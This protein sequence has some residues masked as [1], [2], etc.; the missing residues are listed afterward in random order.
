MSRAVVALG[1]NLG[2]RIGTLRAAVEEIGGLGTVLAVSGVFETDPVGGPE[3][4]A[5]LNA[6]LLLETGLT[7]QALLAALQAI[8]TGHGRTREVRWGARTLDLDIL[9]F[10]GLV[11]DEPDLVLPHPR[12][13]ERAFVLVPWLDADPDA[14]VVGHGPASALLAAIGRDG[15]RSHEEV[16]AR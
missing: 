8:E 9:D 16:L 13:H 1:A 2:D 7:P 11:L 12:A 10:D 6:V 3:Q 15:V 5:Y 4:P 14:V